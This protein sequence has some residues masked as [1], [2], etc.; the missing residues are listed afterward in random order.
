M[1]GVSSAGF[2]TTVLPQ[3]SAGPSFHEAMFSGKFQGVISPTTPSGSRK[4]MSIAARD[5]DRLAVVLVHRARVEVEDVGDHPDLAA[6]VGDRLADVA[7]L[8]AARAPR[9]SPRR[10]SRGGEA[11]GRDRPGRRRATR[12]RRPSRPRPRGR[13]PRR[14][15]AGARRSVSSVAGFRTSIT[16]CA[17]GTGAPRRRA[18]GRALRPRAPRGAR[19]RRA[20][21][22]AAR[23]LEPLDVPSSAHALSTRPSPRRPAPWWWCDLTG[24]RSPRMRPRRL[25]PATVDVVVGE[26]A[27]RVL[28]ALV[29]DHVGEVLDEVAAAQRRSGPRSRG[30]S[31]GWG[32]R[33]RARPP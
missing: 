31:R 3:A 10:A 30:R 13:D 24:A 23:I 8:E 1:S 12:G 9:R 33:A 2:R 29:A 4:V 6:R 20:R 22:D 18:R 26:D 28:V 17:P 15:P 7:G 25:S 16:A 19:G 14:S 11:G 32:G 5:R 21:S 27:R